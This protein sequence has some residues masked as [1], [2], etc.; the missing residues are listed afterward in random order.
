MNNIKTA[1]TLDEPELLSSS[2]WKMRKQ[3]HEEKLSP[4]LDPYL[5][6]V[7]NK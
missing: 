7:L 2:E 3:V 1:I 5:K 4:I 6:D